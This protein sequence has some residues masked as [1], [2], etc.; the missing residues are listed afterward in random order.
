MFII[1]AE[2][3][4]FGAFVFL[5]LGSGEKQPWADG[6]Q[7]STKEQSTKSS[8]HTETE[9]CGQ[10]ESLV[11]SKHLQLHLITLIQCLIDI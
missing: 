3:Y 7:K 5:V 6:P 11:V 1:A 9:I 4:V 2:I 8:S 10:I